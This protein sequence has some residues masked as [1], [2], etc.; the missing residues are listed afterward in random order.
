MCYPGPRYPSP[1]G[2]GGG[3]EPRADG[4]QSHG[5]GVAVLT[6]GDPRC[7]RGAAPH[8]ALSGA[9]CGRRRRP[10]SRRSKGLWRSPKNPSGSVIGFPDIKITS[11]VRPAWRSASRRSA[12]EMPGIIM[13]VRMTSGWKT[14]TILSA[15]VPLVAVVTS[16]HTVARKSRSSPQTRGSSSTIRTRPGLFS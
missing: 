5:R 16:P 1:G 3:H 4:R 12:P 15:S 14:R 8:G 6:C 11:T 7:G 9:S 13:L 10:S 2:T